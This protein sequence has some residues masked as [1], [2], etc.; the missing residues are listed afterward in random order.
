MQSTQNR[1]ATANVVIEELNKAIST[2]EAQLRLAAEKVTLLEKQLAQRDDQVAMLIGCLAEYS[3]VMTSLSQRP[4][5][6]EPGSEPDWAPAVREIVNT[7]CATV[8]ELEQMRRMV[9]VGFAPLD[10][11]AP[12]Q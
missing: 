3:K 4:A 1:R 11:K 10:K 9:P 12:P 2:R 5:P 8:R 7:F 6:P